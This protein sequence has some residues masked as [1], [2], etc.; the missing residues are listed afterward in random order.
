VYFPFIW[1]AQRRLQSTL[2]IKL[3]LE[4]ITKGEL[5]KTGRVVSWLVLSILA[6]KIGIVAGWVDVNDAITWL[7]GGFLR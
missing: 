6:V 1:V 3:R 4:R 5:E 7:P 2:H